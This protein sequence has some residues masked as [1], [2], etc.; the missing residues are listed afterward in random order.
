MANP[1]DTGTFDRWITQR[2]YFRVGPPTTNFGTTGQ[3]NSF[4]TRRIH[5]P[6]YV[7]KL[8]VKV[9]GSITPSGALTKVVKK[10]LAGS[11][12]PDGALT[13]VAEKPLAGS[14]TPSAADLVFLVKKNLAGSI[15]PSGALTTKS[16]SILAEPVQTRD[17][18]YIEQVKF[19]E[20][21]GL[22]LTGGDDQRL[23]VF[24]AQRG[25][26]T[27]DDL[28]DGLR[29]DFYTKDRDIV[30]SSGTTISSGGRDILSEFDSIYPPPGDVPIGGMIM[31]PRPLADLPVGWQECDGT[32]GTFDMRNRFIIGVGTNALGAT[33]GQE[34]VDVSHTHGP[35]SLSTDTDNHT[36]G[37]GTLDTDNDSHTH[38]PGTLA[39]DND[40]H[41]HTVGTY[42]TG[43]TALS[44]LLTAG[45]VMAVGGATLVII[46]PSSHN[47]SITGASA[48]D[49]HNHAVDTGVTANDTHDHAVNAGVT[50]SDGHSHDVDAGVTASAGSA[51][52]DILPPFIAVFY[53]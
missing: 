27:S 16:V 26:Q 36:H 32:N 15:T 52:L 23:D 24:L 17:L 10:N 6:D 21:Y 19:T 49:T 2:I 50:A 3:F 43:N 11:I 44:T 31:W 53:A 4:I 28:I 48:N 30:V 42:A 38:G 46:S 20:P 34:T 35:G 18:M 47:H 40:S 33:G 22:Q 41:T 51:T 39:T 9:S 8:E 12:T 5:F 7:E 29:Q 25:L 13:K 45:G 14:I 1:Q 37:P